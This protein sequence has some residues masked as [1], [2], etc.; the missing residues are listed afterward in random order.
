M[1]NRDRDLTGK[2][3][4]VAGATGAAGVPAVAALAGAG[5]TVVALGHDPIR[6]QDA[7]DGTGAAAAVVDLLD[8]ELVRAVAEQVLAE[9][10]RVDGLVHLVGGWRGGTPIPATDLAD[11]DWLQHR[12]LRTLQVTTKV[13]HDPLVA[14]GGRLAVV[15]SP[16]AHTPSADNACYAAAKAAA[17]AWVLAVAD[18]WRGTQ[19]AAV[20]FEVHALLTPAMRRARPEATFARHTPVQDLAAHL[21][22]L[23]DWPGAELNGTRRSLVP[24]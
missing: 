11:W 1:R 7:V 22:T 19:A 16:Q 5:A 3:V 10:G 8:E 13:L 24:A 15:S 12:V 14:A 2:V 4:V 21:L 20:T 6:L 18:S 9:H 17:D 23:W